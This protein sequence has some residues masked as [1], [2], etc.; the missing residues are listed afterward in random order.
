MTQP[1]TVFFG[2]DG[3]QHEGKNKIYLRTLLY[4]TAQRGQVIESLY[5]TVQRRELKQNFS[6]WVYGEKGDL[7]R[8]SGLFVPR[9]GVTFD[10]HFLLPDDGDKFE[11]LAGDYCIDLFAKLAG[12]NS[13]V[14]LG[15]LKLTVN[16]FHA[17]ELLKERTGIYFDWG[18]ND[19]RYHG[20]AKTKEQIDSDAMKR[21]VKLLSESG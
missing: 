10:H 4:C 3:T 6:V 12:D 21:L 20:H 11:F 1:T 16:D 9:E 5:A 8:G 13:S 14:A 7:K 17:T 19:C 18:A 15:E 2:P